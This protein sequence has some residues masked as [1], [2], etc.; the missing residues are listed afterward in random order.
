M[1]PEPDQIS[2][3]INRSKGKE[4]SLGFAGDTGE[5]E[6]GQIIEVAI[7]EGRS[8]EVDTGKGKKKIR[9]TARAITTPKGLRFIAGGDNAPIR[10]D[11][12]RLLL[13]V[14]ETGQVKS[15]LGKDRKRR[16]QNLQGK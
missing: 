11:D 4:S 9:G 16:R 2:K 15:A 14:K 6:S 8:A 7:I 12:L 3:L 1:T 5:V 13:N 10:V